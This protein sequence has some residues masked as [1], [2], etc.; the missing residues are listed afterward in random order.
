MIC[1]NFESDL[2]QASIDENR[3]RQGI[4]HDE[5][6]RT[7]RFADDQ[8]DWAWVPVGLH[9]NRF[10]LPDRWPRGLEG[11]ETECPGTPA[12]AKHMANGA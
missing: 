12:F 2:L 4:T 11:A 8:I 5:V 3:V 10:G 1:S 6:A 7:T 9:Q